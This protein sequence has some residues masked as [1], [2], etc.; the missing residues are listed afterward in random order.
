MTIPKLGIRTGIR[1]GEWDG[2]RQ[3][4]ERLQVQHNDAIDQT[5][6]EITNIINGTTPITGVAAI[7][8]VA[9]KTDVP[10]TN[11][12]PV[13]YHTTD[14]GHIYAVDPTGRFCTSHFEAP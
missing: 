13:F 4:F 12:T 9:T 2:V 7:T 14:T 5:N 3:T 8:T 11:A 10:A 6:T 1:P